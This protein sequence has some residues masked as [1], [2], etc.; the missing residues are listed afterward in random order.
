MS[1]SV[2]LLKYNLKLLYSIKMV[3]VQE[4]SILSYLFGTDY[5]S[6]SVAYV[7]FREICREESL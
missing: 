2:T 4:T 6:Y 1:R 7:C 5:I 3:P